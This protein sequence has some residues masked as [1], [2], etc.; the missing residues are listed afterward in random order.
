MVEVEPSPQEKNGVR[1]FPD[2][3]N[4]VGGFGASEDQSCGVA[5]LGAAGKPASGLSAVWRI[6]PHAAAP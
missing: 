5:V 2:V 6:A 1:L 3:L 4:P